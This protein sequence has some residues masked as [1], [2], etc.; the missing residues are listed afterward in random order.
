MT[1]RIKEPKGMPADIAQCPECGWTGQK[2]DFEVD[3]NERKCP[4]CQYTIRSY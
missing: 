3:G 2:A 4:A 1:Y